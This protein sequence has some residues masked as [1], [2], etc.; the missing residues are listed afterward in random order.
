[1]STQTPI[2]DRVNNPIECYQDI[3]VAKW[4]TKNSP[5]QRNNECS[6]IQLIT[7]NASTTDLESHP[8]ATLNLAKVFQKNETVTRYK[9]DSTSKSSKFR[10]TAIKNEQ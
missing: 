6:T 7:S 8:V 9:K 1:M 3:P 10:E 2:G 5:Q 4:S